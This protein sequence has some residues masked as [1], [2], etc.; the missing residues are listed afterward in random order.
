MAFAY[1]ADKPGG[2]EVLE[3]R[4]IETPAPNAEEVVISQTKVGLNYIDV[5]MFY[6]RRVL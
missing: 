5:Y 3:W 2:I 4:D 6:R 1:C